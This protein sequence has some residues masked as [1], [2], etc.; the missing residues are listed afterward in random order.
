MKASQLT[1]YEKKRLNLNRNCYICD[2]P[3]RDY[4]QI[5]FIKTRDRRWVQYN[6]YHT[7]CA[8]KYGIKEVTWNEKE[9]KRP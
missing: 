9:E 7:A 1:E 3:I 6:F 5:D 4:E 8:I 2:Q